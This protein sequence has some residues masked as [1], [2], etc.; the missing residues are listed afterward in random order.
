MKAIFYSLVVMV[1]F[2]SA[3]QNH[4]AEEEAHDHSDEAATFQFT[5]Y[6]SGWELFAE[7]EP[8]IKDATSGILTHITDLA[9]FSPLTEGTVTVSLIIGTN[10]I[11]Q[12]LEKP[13]REGIYLFNLQPGVTGTGKLLFEIATPDSTYSITINGV[14][15]F[16]DEHDAIHTAEEAAIE[17]PN[18]ITFTKEQSWKIDFVTGTPRM[19]QFGEVIKTTARIQPAQGEEVILTAQTNG[20]VNFGGKTL[21]EGVPVSGGQT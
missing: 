10:G 3:C 14:T 9:D 4:H 16:A 8:F 2:F 1:L 20:V 17:N 15:V 12:T 21:T 6:Q 5:A 7:A 13:T 11:R 19:I 18:A